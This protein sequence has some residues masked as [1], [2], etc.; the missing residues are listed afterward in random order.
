MATKKE[1]VKDSVT[2]VKR[3]TL[4]LSLTE[5][6]KKFLK[7]YAALKGKTVAG[8]IKDWIDAARLESK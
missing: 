3:T 7:S 5:E 2:T 6:D 1:V 4:S 8:V